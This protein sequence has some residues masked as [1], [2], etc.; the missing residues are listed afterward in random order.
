MNKRDKQYHDFF[1]SMGYEFVY[2]P[3]K[4]GFMIK[5]IGYAKVCDLP[6]S[7]FIIKEAEKAGKKMQ[8]ILLEGNLTFKCY[9]LF[10]NDHGW[11]SAMFV[12]EGDKYSPLFYNED[13]LIDSFP[14]TTKQTAI[15]INGDIVCQRCGSVNDFIVEKPSI[16]YKLTCQCGSFIKNSGTNA[17]AILYFGKYKGREIASMKSDDELKYL[18]WL[19]NNSD[20]I[21]GKLRTSIINHLSL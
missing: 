9:R 5:G 16:H 8:I 14:E 18:E 10:S 17:P 21:Q 15:S 3:D 20:S 11:Y 7:D 13:Y 2:H 4:S 1:K 19:I 6:A 12:K